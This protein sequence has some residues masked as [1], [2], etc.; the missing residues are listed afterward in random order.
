MMVEEQLHIVADFT[1]EL[2]RLNCGMHRSHSLLA[3]Y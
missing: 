2:L 3:N 1:S